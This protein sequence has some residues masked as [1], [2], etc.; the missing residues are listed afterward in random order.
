MFLRNYWYVAASDQEVQAKPL[1]RTIL[2]EPI[3]FFRTEDGTPAAMEDRCPHRQA[4]AVDGQ[5]RR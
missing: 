1:G 5:A 4:A 2:G 3:V